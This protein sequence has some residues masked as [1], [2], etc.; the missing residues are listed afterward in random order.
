ML[1]EIRIREKLIEAFQPLHIEVINESSNHHVPQ[2]SET[3]FLIVVVSDSFEGESRIERQ[4]RVHLVLGDELRNG[5]HA[6]SQ[7]LMTVQEW[8]ASGKA[9][10]KSP[11]CSSRKN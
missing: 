10:H 8:E 3:H 1:V 7:R 2:G 9:Y 5:V 11:A 6:L 4:R